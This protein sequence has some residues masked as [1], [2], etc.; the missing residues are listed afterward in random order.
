MSSF[1]F[2]NAPDCIIDDVT[3]LAFAD[4]PSGISSLADT[5]FGSQV[6]REK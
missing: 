6:C 4:M 1:T 5:D 2:P 3:C